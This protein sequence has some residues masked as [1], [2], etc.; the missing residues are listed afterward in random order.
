MPARFFFYRSA[1]N[2]SKLSLPELRQRLLRAARRVVGL[3]A[4]V[5]ILILSICSKPPMRNFAL[6]RRPV[7]LR[8]KSVTKC[9]REI[10]GI[11]KLVYPQSFT[12]VARAE[13]FI[14]FY[15]GLKTCSTLTGIPQLRKRF[16]S[17]YSSLLSFG[18]QVMDAPE[19]S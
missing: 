19:P 18:S 14:N 15:A 9:I 1:P 6:Q 2:P 11:L 13:G 10:I 7:N 12:S 8:R 16:R 4:F 3:A 5:L 17:D